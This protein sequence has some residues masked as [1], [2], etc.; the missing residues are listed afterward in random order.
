MNQSSPRHLIRGVA[1]AARAASR[2]VAKASAAQRTS[3]LRA[4][5]DAIDRSTPAILAANA[6]DMAA[7]GSRT[8][9]PAMLDRLRL[10]DARVAQLSRAVR[11]IAEAPDL[12]GRVEK[13]E[14][15]PNGLEVQRVRIPLGVIAMIYEARPN[16]TTDAAAL[17]LKSGNACILRGGSEAFE[18]NRALAA[19][20]R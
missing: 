7:A 13:T 15:R 8:L 1:E 12:L 9:A 10:D 5:A 20:V 14:T 16:V 18:S 19:A 6:K 4:I 11:E 17:C 2:L 3:G